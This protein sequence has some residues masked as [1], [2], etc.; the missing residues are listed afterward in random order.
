[1]VLKYRQFLKSSNLRRGLFRFVGDFVA[2]GMDEFEFKSPC[3]SIGE[4]V[5][6]FETGLLHACGVVFG[7]GAE[8]LDADG[9]DGEFAAQQPCQR[10]EAVAASHSYG[11][12][13]ANC[14]QAFLQHCLHMLHK[15]VHVVVG[16]VDVVEHVV[17]RCVVVDE[18]FRDCLTSF[19]QSLFIVSTG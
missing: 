15:L 14:R 6:R 12:G 17:A 10:V 11:V 4:R 16:L 9:A 8:F 19:G 18:K 2:A 13:D 7:G 3:K 5:W 1:M